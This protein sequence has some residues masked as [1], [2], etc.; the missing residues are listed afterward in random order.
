MAIE[1]VRN[2]HAAML[3]GFPTYKESLCTDDPEGFFTIPFRDRVPPPPNSEA[4]ELLHFAVTAD[5]GK[6]WEIAAT[7]YQQFLQFMAAPERHGAELCS[8]FLFSELKD[9][10]TGE[11]VR[12]NLNLPDSE[13]AGS[14]V[15]VIFSDA[16]QFRGDLEQRRRCVDAMLRPIFPELTIGDT[17]DGFSVTT[18]SSQTFVFAP[19]HQALQ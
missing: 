10:S 16:S 17:G 6:A 4:I 19:V 2:A 8:M 1:E 7:N 18:S 13:A 12:L 3:G 9:P 14:T 15:Q 11:A 5:L